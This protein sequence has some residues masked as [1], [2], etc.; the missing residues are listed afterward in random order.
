MM[1]W[2][3]RRKSEISRTA[4]GF[5]EAGERR[6][7]KT[8][9]VL[10]VAMFAAGVFFGWRALDDL[11]RV[12]ARPPELS[13]CAARYLSREGTYQPTPLRSPLAE[14]IG[15]SFYFY[16]D[17]RQCRWNDLET[18]HGIPGLMAKREPIESAL[19]ELSQKYAE[20]SRNL[21]DARRR[22]RDVENQYGI[23]LEE[24][25]TQIQRELLSKFGGEPA[26]PPAP[27]Q[28]FPVTPAVQGEI[29]NL[30]AEET[31]LEGVLAGYEAERR[32][33]EAELKAVDEELKQ[34]YAPV[35]AAHDRRL[36][37]Y[38]FKVFLLQLALVAPLF[39][40]ALWGYVRLL[41]RDSPYAV[42]FTAVVAVLGLL[43]LRVLLFW[44]WGLFLA[45]IV[46]VLLQWFRR[47]ELIRSIVFYLGM[48]LSF[49]VFGG[50]VYYLQ[51]RIFD[52]ARVAIRRFRA[53]QCPH[54]QTSLDLAASHC[55]NCG[56]KVR[57]RCAVCGNLRYV[58]LPACPHCGN[59]V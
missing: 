25:Q 29:Q 16:E 46:E 15:E 27:R 12:P 14:S 6:T 39:L 28:V 20:A 47:F 30:R 48:L 22:R 8:G 34:A 32:S 35:F 26:K 21:E 13:H 56:S 54:C 19:R 57:E 55:P 50:A 41:A 31:R 53:K 23:G 24:I 17:S 33:K 1:P 44:F 52:P 4:P 40:L 59:R 51:K 11:A 58:G 3:F 9:I 37:L 7:P 42:I 5:E 43:A 45:R 18:S 10:L 2:P 38:E 49:A 36:R